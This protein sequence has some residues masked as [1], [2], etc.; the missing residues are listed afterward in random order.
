MPK[1]KLFLAVDLQP[2]VSCH[3]FIKSGHRLC[4]LYVVLYGYIYVSV[5]ECVSL[6]KYIFEFICVSGFPIWHIV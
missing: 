5:C 1:S 2:W 6:Y 3:L 4:Y